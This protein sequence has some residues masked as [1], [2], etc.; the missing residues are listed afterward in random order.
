MIFLTFGTG[1]GAGLILDGRLYTGTN[2]M[3]GEVGHVRAEKDGPEG[4][5]K[6]GSF[7]GFCSGAGIAKMAGGVSAR[8]VVERADA[9]DE[10]MLAVLR[11]SARHLGSCLAMLMDLLNPQRIVIGSVYARAERHF[12]D[13]GPARDRGRGAAALARRLR[14]ASR[15]SGRR[16]RR[17]GGAVGGHR[18]RAASKNQ[19]RSEEASSMKRSAHQPGDAVGG[20]VPARQQHPSARVCLLAA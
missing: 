20:Y 12:R 16:H 7:E 18:R 6:R 1:F 9:G 5:G 17:Y 8:E 15:P 4:Y 10:A 2:D 14:S 3:A 13:V 19:W 11:E